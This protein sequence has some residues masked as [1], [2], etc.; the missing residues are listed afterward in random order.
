MMYAV[1]M[2]PCG[3]GWWRREES[4]WQCWW[5]LGSCGEVMFANQ[6]VAAWLQWECMVVVDSC[7]EESSW[8]KHEQYGGGCDVGVG[9]LG[10]GN[11]YVNIGKCAIYRVGR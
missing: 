8:S 5:W 9:I 7:W 2:S 1:L 4:L 3:G 6:E 10:L 11:C